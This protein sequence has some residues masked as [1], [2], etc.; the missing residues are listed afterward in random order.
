MQSIF[1]LK[2]TTYDAPGAS[3]EQEVLFLEIAEVNP[4]IKDGIEG[5][6]VE[7]TGKV[8]VQASKMPAGYLAKRI[9]AYAIAHPDEMKDLNFFQLERSSPTINNLVERT[10]SFVY[11]FSG[12]YDPEVGTLESITFEVVT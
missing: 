8:Y 3:E 9:R 1:D 5:A 4:R 12:Q 6:R 11:F 2:R 10:F 7:G